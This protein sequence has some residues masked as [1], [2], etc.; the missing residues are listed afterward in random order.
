MPQRNRWPTEAE[1]Q[2]IEAI[3]IFARIA[4]LADATFDAIECGDTQ[5]AVMHLGRLRNRA[6]KGKYLLAYLPDMNVF[7]G[8]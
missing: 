4:D 5:Q 1:M 7:D 6:M 3:A 2:R 8:E